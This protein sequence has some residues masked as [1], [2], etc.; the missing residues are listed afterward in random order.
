MQ[1]VEILVF[2]LSLVWVVKI[3]RLAKRNPWFWGG[4]F[5]VIVLVLERLAFGLGIPRIIGEICGIG[6]TLILLAL[7]KKAGFRY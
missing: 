3:A 2:A 1:L 5:T 6:A 7:A 4:V